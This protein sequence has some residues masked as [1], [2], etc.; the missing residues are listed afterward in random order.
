MNQRMT[1][2]SAL[3]KAAGTA[4]LI[5]T[6]A[7]LAGRIAAAEVAGGTALKGRIN[8]SACRWCYNKI[9]LEELCAAVKDMG[10]KSLE[11]LKLDDLPT[12]KKH[13]LICAMVTGAYWPVCM[14][15]RNRVAV[16]PKTCPESTMRSARSRP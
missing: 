10:I 8:H 9:P 13:G 14:V 5:G 3:T 11:I 7:G 1:R 4:A 2:R 6:S 15:D 16:I 12:L